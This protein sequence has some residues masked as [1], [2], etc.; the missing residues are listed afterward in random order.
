MIRGLCLSRGDR[1]GRLFDGEDVIPAKPRAWMH[2]FL[3]RQYSKHE[4]G[5]VVLRRDGQQ[6]QEAAAHCF[7][8]AEAT[9]LCNPLD[10][11]A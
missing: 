6:A 8:R 2:Y 5:T 4:S 10:R 9:T 7:L 3:V 11:K 1:L